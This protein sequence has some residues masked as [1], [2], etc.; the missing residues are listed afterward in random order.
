[1]NYVIFVDEFFCSIQGIWFID[2]DYNGF[3]LE[4]K[5]GKFYSIINNTVNKL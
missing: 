1:M 3:G 5:I 2:H 4:I